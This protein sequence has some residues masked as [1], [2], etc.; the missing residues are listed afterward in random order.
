[1]CVC[2]GGGAHTGV[3]DRD[4]AVTHLRMSTYPLI[5]AL[6]RLSGSPLASLVMVAM[7]ARGQAGGGAH[8]TLTAKQ[9]S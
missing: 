4:Q 1:M 3:Q 9:Q 5:C 7:A 8:R 2:R 6:C